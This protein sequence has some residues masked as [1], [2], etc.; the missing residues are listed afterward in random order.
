MEKSHWSL[1]TIL[2][3]MIATEMNV[4]QHRAGEREDQRGW[5]AEGAAE[6]EYDSSGTRLGS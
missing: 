3:M 6:R 5:E 4:Q 2:M 1:P